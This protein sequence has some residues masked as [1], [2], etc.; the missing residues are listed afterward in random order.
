MKRLLT[1]TLILICAV[2]L[3][4]QNDTLT[5]WKFAE[6]VG[7]T[8]G[9]KS[10]LIIQIDYGQGV[11]SYISKIK[12]AETFTSMVDAMNYMAETGWEFVDAY[13]YLGQGSFPVYHWIIRHKV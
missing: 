11:N 10:E 8:K 13:A 6:I 4:A 2:S 12:T 7:V 9:F 5:K 3:N 1:I